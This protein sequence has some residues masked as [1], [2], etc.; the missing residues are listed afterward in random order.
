[1]NVTN[2]QITLNELL[3][4]SKEVTRVLISNSDVNTFRIDFN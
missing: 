4:I 1:M 2:K 3:S